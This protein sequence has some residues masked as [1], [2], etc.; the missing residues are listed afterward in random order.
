MTQGPA[1]PTARAILQIRNRLGLHARAAVQ[2]VKT[3]SQFEAEIT[4]AKDG[5]VV[6]GKSIMGVMTLAAEQGTEIELVASG[7]QA[8]EALAAITSLVEAGFH[9]GEDRN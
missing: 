1:Q 9:L 3:A 4:V 6:S 8:E 7:P 2:L 5:Q